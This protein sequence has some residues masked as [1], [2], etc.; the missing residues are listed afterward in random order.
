MPGSSTRRCGGARHEWRAV[1]TREE[2][3]VLADDAGFSPARRTLLSWTVDHDPEHVAAAFAPVELLW[4]G[5][6]GA[7]P[8][9]RL[10]AWGA[11]ATLRTGCL[12]LSLDAPRPWE[13]F[14][15]R[16][17]LV[18]SAFPDLKLK[19]ATLLAERELPARLLAPVLA[20]ATLDFVSTANPRD[21]HDRRAL[22]TY[23][24][25]L[26]VE[27]VEQ[28][29]ALLTTDGPL[30]PVEGRAAMAGTRTRCRNEGDGE[31]SR[32]EHPDDARVSQPRRRGQRPDRHVRRRC[33]PEAPHPL[34]HEGRRRQRPDARR[35]RR[36]T[37][38]PTCRPSASS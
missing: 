11:P 8:H 14:A 26:G 23:V 33:P 36:S 17:A 16:S 2:A 15:G 12:C 19:L 25:R 18:A 24:N 35:G 31:A 20:A 1:R 13:V 5:L 28:Y 29:L 3:A 30:V 32:P 21:G 6:E 4:L 22:E 27:Q 34:A 38:P 37:S 7:P 10:D 9:G